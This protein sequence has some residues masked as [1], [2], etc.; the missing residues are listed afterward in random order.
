MAEK[1]RKLL[2]INFF[3]AFVPP[4]SGGE[5]R[6]Y[7]L[8]RYLSEAF[9]VTLLSATYADA[10]TE[11]IE[12]SPSFRE[13]RVPKPREADQIHWKLDNERIGPECSG[14]ALALAGEF[15]TE[16]GRRMG[17]L[18]RAADVVVHES[19]FTLPYDRGAGSDGKLRMYNAYNVEYRLAEQMFEGEIGR[20]G[21]AFVRELEA[22]L[23]GCCSA[24]LAISEEERGAF[25]DAFGFPSERIF[26]APNGYEPVAA[27][28]PAPARERSALF[29]GS[30]HPPNVEALAF[31]AEELAPALKDVTFYALGSVCKAYDKP[32]PANVKLLGFVDAAEKDALLWRCGAAINPLRSGAGTNLKMLD[33]MGH[34]A[35][36]L[37]TPIGA[38]GLEIEAGTQAAISELDGFA[39]ALR[40]LL[41]DAGAS[42]A[43]GERG[44]GFARARYTWE[45]IAARSAQAIAQTLSAPAVASARKRILAVCDYETHRAAG[46]GQVR[47]NE[48]LTE[49]GREFDVTLLCLNNGESEERCTI[50]PG[51]VQRSIPKTAAHRREDVKSLKGYSVSVADLVAAKHCLD[52]EA[53]LAAFREEL[54]RADL[55]DFEHCFLAPLLSLVP[56]A[57]PVVHSSHNVE[58]ELK[59]EL[60]AS[61]EDGDKWIELAEQLEREVASRADLVFCVSDADAA[62]LRERYGA[63]RVLTV[64]NGVRLPQVHRNGLAREE[65]PEQPP[66]AVFVGS[67][68]PPNVRAAQ[69]IVDELAARNPRVNFALVG[70]VCEAIDVAEVPPNVAL[71][72]FLSLADKQ[73][74]FA[75]ADLAVNP[76]F[77]GG[78]SSLKVPDFLAAG[79]PLLTSPIGVRGFGGL[80]AGTHYI[81]A[82]PE[83]MA[84]WIPKLCGDRGLS[85]RISAEAMDYVATHLDWRVLG[86]RMRR[87][88]RQLIGRDGPCRMLVL[89]Y[90]FGEP[91]RGG[92]EVYLLNL[93]R[94]LEK[95]EGLEIDV[96][97]PAVGPIHDRLHFSADYEPP[98]AT[99]GVPT[100]KGQVRLFRPDPPPADRFAQAAILNSAW[101]QESLRIGAD[102]AVDIGPGLLGGWNYPERSDGRVVRW[103]GRIAQALLP[104]GSEGVRI[105]GVALQPVRVSVRVDDIEL[106]AKNVSGRFSFRHAFAGPGTLL[107]LRVSALMHSED[108]AR[109]LGVIVSAIDAVGADG[110]TAAIDLGEGM[111][112]RA[113]RAAPERWIGELIA[114]AKRRARDVDRRFCRIRGPHSAEM[115]RWLDRHAAD[116]DVILAQGVPFASSLLGVRTAARHGLPSIVLPHFHMEDRYYH[117]RD[118]YDAFAAA[119]RV[120]AFPEESRRAFF[121]KV[122]AHSVGIA[123][124]GL[125]AADFAPDFVARGR[126]AFARLHRGERPFVLVLGRKTAA[127]HYAAT[128]QACQRL[129]AAGTGV[130]VV[131][132]GP[133]DDGAPL[134]GEGVYYYGPQPRE[135][136]VGALSQA[137]CLANMSESE[138]FGIVLLESWMAGRPVVAR[139]STAAFAE[140]VEEGE[141]GYLADSVD[142]LAAQLK[143]Y[144]DDRDLADRHGAAG[145]D[146]ARGFGWDG[147]ADRLWDIVSGVLDE[148][149]FGAAREGAPP[150]A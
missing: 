17:E 67:A 35:P 60:L 42:R 38:R 116:Y 36:V 92:A 79:L 129:N 62:R 57:M 63:R 94:A 40:G 99:D 84:E 12:H 46:G 101:M 122:G 90:R 117:W 73:A 16:L 39:G 43:L 69:F 37:S 28:E 93:L 9:D 61:R 52:N 115:E 78:G 131:L 138:S 56:Q 21:A 59:R 6:Y 65:R 91:A 85:A 150:A 82:G 3:P 14:L 113:R 147:V 8:Y 127:K 22:R 54:A 25:H 88:L 87:E 139:G 128:V 83:A 109:E 44:A 31:I 32:V 41:D 142:E 23:L 55:V 120:L 98:T 96:V 106:E 64:E 27:P 24:L 71:L 89:T 135:V 5:Q 100:M 95:R 144:I 130:D 53:L 51:V 148:R 77:E 30:A 132:I 68:H 149:R 111:E 118:F 7:M 137:R 20:R 80:R 133:D 66:L 47:I 121:D 76:L 34:A 58:A 123:G 134:A 13:I 126:E 105:A 74:L 141:N 136:V 104:E 146:I 125:N 103:T 107:E 97:A 11:T 70:S 108:D 124:G 15:D 102:L 1:R 72:G 86:G 4:R 110:E 140:L 19:P 49:L 18:V 2:A 50:A 112:E 10:K 29:L 75:L 26:L 81:E 114:A 33:Y 143:R 119:D 145:R 48:L 45:A